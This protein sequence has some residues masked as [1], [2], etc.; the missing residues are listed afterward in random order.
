L[1]EQLRAQQSAGAGKPLSTQVDLPLSNAGKRLLAYAAEEAER[2]TDR[3]I[4]TEHMVL[5][6]LRESG[7]AADLLQQYGVDLTQAREQIRGQ[8]R[9]EVLRAEAGPETRPSQPT[10]FD[11]NVEFV[12]AAND[13]L[14]AVVTSP[15][16]V[17]AI[18]E[19]VTFAGDE[20]SRSFRVV[21]VSYSF[22]NA[23]AM[24]AF[25]RKS[26]RIRVSLELLAKEI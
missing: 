9:Y 3:H 24:Q 26:P 12:D 18:G 25:S 1:E 10:A 15:A 22:P 6:L 21:N 2:L 17:P 19:E 23:A 11:V 5:S 13:S 14:I 16:V 4:G 20:E 7:P 8:G